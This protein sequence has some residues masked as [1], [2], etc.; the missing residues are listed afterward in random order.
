M[1]SRR[2]TLSL[3]IQYGS[4]HTPVTVSNVR[5]KPGIQLLLVNTMYKKTIAILTFALIAGL[6]TNISSAQST[7]SK[8]QEKKTVKQGSGDKKPAQKEEKKPL[9]L[10]MAGGNIEMQATGNWTKK[11]GASQFVDHELKVPKVKGDPANGR[12]TIGR[13][14]GGIQANMDRWKAQFV[15]QAKYKTRTVKVNEMEIKVLEVE[16]TF[17]EALRGPM[18]PKNKRE[19]YRMFAALADSKKGLIYFKLTGPKATLEA[20]KKYFD[21]LLKSVK[22]K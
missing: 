12:L 1:R 9:M 8:T 7:D 20:N 4:E 21:Q 14:G 19:N 22:V 3:G 5:R 17:N 16:G 18:G 6:A 15:G 13:T 11:E 2:R 10:K